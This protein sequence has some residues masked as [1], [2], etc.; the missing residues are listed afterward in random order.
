MK[1]MRAL[2]YALVAVIILTTLVAPA[3]PAGRHPPLR[4]PRRPPWPNRPRR[5]KPPKRRNRPRRLRPTAAP[6]ATKAP[7]PNKAPVAAALK[8]PIPYPDP[9]K[10]EVGAEPVK[11]QK[12][13]EIVT[14]KALPE[15]KEPAWV[16]DL[17]KAGKLPAVKDRLPK[18]PRVILKSG[19]A[20]GTGVYGDVGRFFSACPTAGWNRTAGTSAGWFGIES[21]SSNYD[22][23]VRMGPFFRTDVDTEP[24]PQLAKSWEWSADG[25]QLTMKLMEGVKWSDGVPFNADDVMFTWED[26]VNDKNVNATVQADRFKFGDQPA[27]LEKVDDYTIKWT[28]GAAKP[29]TALYDMAE[30]RLNIMPAH[31]LK[32]KHPKYNKEMDYKKFANFPDQ[33]LPQVTTGPFAATE[34]K[35]DELLIMRRNPYFY[36]VDETG[37]QLPYLDEIQYQKGPSGTGRTL[38]VMAG[39][40][41]Q[42][43]L[44]NPSVF[45]EALKKA[46][47]PNSPNKITWGPETLGYRVDVNQSVD[48]GVKD[49]RDKAVRGLFR[50]VKFR[51]ALSQGMD[52]DGIT[53]A[54][55]RGPFL[56][57][58]RR[59]LP[60]HAGVR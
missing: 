28:F 17:V 53:Q 3:A 43:N 18:E 46:S 57:V 20:D 42:D 29:P 14:Y 34:Y 37:Q 32:A 54:I 23:L 21:Y 9:P 55:I 6:A 45:V 25:K 19:T 59:R 52:R 56:R 58:A 48:M 4:Q 41:D 50:D 44:E 22:S 36:A 40:C 26:Y 7:E 5:L 31:I 30:G 47:E 35:T 2:Q 16:T 12:I 38:C 24:L 27:K 1:V 49:D 39:G 51:R 10:I 8:A 15:Y 11:R 13:S 33:E 60:R